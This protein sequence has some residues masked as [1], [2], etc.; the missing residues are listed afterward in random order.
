[1]ASS[2]LLYRCALLQTSKLRY[3]EA[4]TEDRTMMDPALLPN[5]YDFIAHTYPFSY[6]TTLEQDALAARVHISYH[7]RGTDLRDEELTHRGIFL[8]RTGAVEER[9]EDGTLRARLSVGDLFGFTQLDLTGKS[10]YYVHC[11]ENTLLYLIDRGMLHLLMDRNPS[12][13]QF[14]D[15]HEGVR[16]EGSRSYLQKNSGAQFFIKPVKEFCRA[17]VTVIAPANTLQETAQSMHRHMSDMA[18]VRD[19]SETVGIVTKSDLTYRALAN[20]LP[21]TTPVT[22]VMSRNVIAVDGNRPLYEAFE[23]MISRNIKNLP[24]TLNGELY[25][26][27]DPKMLLQ[28]SQLEAIYLIKRIARAPD[29]ESLIALKDKRTEIFITLCNFNLEPP[30]ISQVMTAIADSFIKRLCNLA[31]ARLGPPPCAYAFMVAGSQARSEMQLLSDQDNAIITGRDIDATERLYFTAL[32]DFVCNNLDKCGYPLCEGHYMALTPRWCQS[33]ETWENYYRT[34]IRE[35]DD[36][37]LL[38]MSVFLDLRHIA[39]DPYLTTR[40]RRLFLKEAG[41]NR[42][43]LSLLAGAALSV[44]PPLGMFRQFVLTRD[45]QNRSSFNIKKQG[46]NIV[47]EMARVYALSSGSEAYDTLDRLEE[48]SARGLLDPALKRELT[49]AYL[50]ITH[51]RLEHQKEALEAGETA[52]NHLEPG[53]LTQFERNH[54]R[55]AFR[56]LSKA[57]E[58][59]AF[60]FRGTF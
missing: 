3:D 1:M 26:S 21:V 46:V 55:D 38:D 7:A 19:G 60:R 6:L 16:L 34:W 20:A 59:M 13:R 44:S 35:I 11:L 10:S 42:R 18:V 39:G 41:E 8:I 22:E 24:V 40:L 30:L 12:L 47:M 25:G 4:V 52:G 56:I 31:E 51:V 17:D 32:A 57:Q 58:G 27:I 23:L 2:P 43:F 36:K 29:V 53:R 49:E 48:A 15:S 37:T 45:G 9:L 54:L 14:F 50:F 28:N 33:I 5:I